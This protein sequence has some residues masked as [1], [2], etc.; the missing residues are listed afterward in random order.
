MQV[1]HLQ[2]QVTT[3]RKWYFHILNHS[4]PPTD[5]Q[6]GMKTII[7]DPQLFKSAYVKFQLPREKINTDFCVG[8]GAPNTPQNPCCSRVN[9]IAFSTSHSSKLLKLKGDYRN[10]KFVAKSDKNAGSLE[11]WHVQMVGSGGNH[12]V[13]NFWGLHLHWVGS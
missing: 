3:N 6:L 7:L 11:T 2:I 1:L 10:S 5:S 9:W 12:S 13:V 8:I 4:F